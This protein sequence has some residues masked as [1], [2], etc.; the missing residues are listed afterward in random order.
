MLYQ[1]DSLLAGLWN[2]M[3]GGALGRTIRVDECLVSQQYLHS[4][5]CRS[6]DT[7]LCGGGEYRIHLGIQLPGRRVHVTSRNQ[8]GCLVHDGTGDCG[9][10]KWGWAIRW[11]RSR[12]HLHHD[13]WAF[14][15]EGGHLYECSLWH[16]SC[17][18]PICRRGRPW[19]YLGFR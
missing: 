4:A 12:W 1:R 13:R 9:F 5:G 11:G 18:R 16:L 8:L 6:W 15:A 3:G 7:R 19:K 2:S 17:Q 10:D 14:L